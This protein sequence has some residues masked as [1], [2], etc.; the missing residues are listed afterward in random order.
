[1]STIQ[2]PEAGSIGEGLLSQ[3]VPPDGVYDEMLAFPGDLRTHWQG[4]VRA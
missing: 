4:M 3:Y 2:I 1:M